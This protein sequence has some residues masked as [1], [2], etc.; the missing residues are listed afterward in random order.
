MA[1]ISQYLLE[2]TGA[3]VQQAITD[4]LVNLPY[5]LGLKANSSDVLTKTN[6]VAY[7]P[8]EQYHPA[9]KGYVDSVRSTVA[10]GQT[11]TGE[12]GTQA[13]V[14]NS[15]DE[16]DAILNFTIPKGDTGNAAGF[17]TPTATTT[18]LQPGEDA[19]VSLVAS[20]PATNKKFDF[21]F[22]IPKGLK[23]DTGDQGYYI[24]SVVKT[25]GTG[26][27]GT[28]DVYTIYMNDPSSTVVGTFNVYNGR[29]GTGVGT[30]TSVGATCTDNSLSISNSPVT[31]FG[32]I[33]INHTNTITPQSTLGVYAIS[34]DSH[35]HI[36]GYGQPS[37][38]ESISNKV[39]SITSSSTNTEYP[40]AAAVWNL[41]N[42]IIDGDE[43]YY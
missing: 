23:G 38:Y 34:F 5:T 31:S 29:D 1:T 11:T 18:T 24:D 37:T 20:G 26:T 35:G 28:T 30:V 42:S 8:T 14:V 17:D 9:T 7:I 32:D 15:G 36:T 27:P 33:T 22:G 6:V 16:H 2:N 43:I 3:E 12:P 39:T 41:F 25:S 4:A 19:T 21:T 40:S 13:S 10:V